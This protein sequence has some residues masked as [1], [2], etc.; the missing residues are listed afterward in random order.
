MFVAI[1][2]TSRPLPPT[3]TISSSAPSSQ[4]C[5][6]SS[7][8]RHLRD[9]RRRCGIS[10]HRVSSCTVRTEHRSRAATSRS[11]TPSLTRG[12][13]A[14]ASL[15]NINGCSHDA[16]GTRLVR[17]RTRKTE[18]ARDVRGTEGSGHV[19]RWKNPCKHGT[20]THDREMNSVL[21][22]RRRNL[23]ELAATSGFCRASPA[24]PEV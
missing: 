4:A 11:V 24:F 12:G 17:S 7:R 9:G 16:L 1:G 3:S 2:R 15:G 8:S 14:L 19:R 23:R 21:F 10:P 6:S 18:R 22:G 5:N 13:Q 20:E